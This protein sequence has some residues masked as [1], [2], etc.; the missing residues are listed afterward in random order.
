MVDHAT[1]IRVSVLVS[2]LLSCG[3][4]F[5]L[6]VLLLTWLHSLLVIHEAGSK[7]TVIRST[8]CRFLLHLSVC[9]FFT[10]LSYVASFFV[11]T[12]EVRWYCITEASIMVIFEYASLLWTCSIGNYP[13]YLER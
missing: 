7:N 12:F 8:L 2:G 11:T 10:A 6:F 9:D 3:G 13:F 1:G 4:S 5:C